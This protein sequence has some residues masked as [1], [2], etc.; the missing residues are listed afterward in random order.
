MFGLD[1]LNPSIAISEMLL[2]LALAALVGWLLGR[3]ALNGR[4]KALRTNIADREAELTNVRQPKTTVEPA[5]TEPLVSHASINDSHAEPVLDTKTTLLSSDSSESMA[6]FSQEKVPGIKPADMLEEPYIEVPSRNNEP[7][8]APNTAEESTPIVRNTSPVA[9]TGQDLVSGSSL[10]SGQ[11][12]SGTS[13]PDQS[14]LRTSVPGTSE[15]AVL[16]R[17]AAR[18][19]E[20]NFDRIGRATAAEADDLKDIIGIGPFLERKLN[21]IGIY[22]YRQVANF[23]KEDADTVNRIIEFFP[24]RIERDNWVDQSQTFHERKYGARK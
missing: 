16:S 4:I 13:V 12:T 20:V 6:T 23:T 9:A 3:L 2:L 7:F 1:P 10:R 17:I 15:A 5:Y 21:A 19:H 22:T 14:M 11:D 8:E 18:A 24:G